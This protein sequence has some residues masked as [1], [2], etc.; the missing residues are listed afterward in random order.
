MGPEPCSLSS[1]E[2]HSGWPGPTLPGVPF[3]PQQETATPHPPISADEARRDRGVLSPHV[4][5]PCKCGCQASRA[6]TTPLGQPAATRA[7]PSAHGLLGTGPETRLE[8]S[9]TSR[10]ASFPLLWFL[11]MAPEPRGHLRAQG[12]CRAWVPAG[13]RPA[14]MA[15]G[16]PAGASLC[17]GRLRAPAGGLPPRAG[18]AGRGR[19]LGSPLPG[20][21]AGRAASPP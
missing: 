9:P 13:T 6:I 21:G 2:P 14:P 1:P 12:Q 7:S 8:V 20:K 16:I 4:A 5:P 17:A 3:V 19:H 11:V 15:P 18:P 10:E